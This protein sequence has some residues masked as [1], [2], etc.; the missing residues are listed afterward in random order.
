ML[1]DGNGRW[2]FYW[3]FF[4]KV[5]IV[6]GGEGRGL[7]FFTFFYF[8]VCNFLGF[9]T[10]KGGGGGGGGKWGMGVF[11]IKKSFC[12]NFSVIFFTFKG[13]KGGTCLRSINIICIY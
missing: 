5:L 9:F 4:L 12:V 10:L 13:G 1:K 8:H 7:Y 11:F 6:D 2:V 3:Y